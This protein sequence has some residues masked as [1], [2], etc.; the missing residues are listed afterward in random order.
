MP[1]PLEIRIG[2]RQIHVP[3]KSFQYF[4]YFYVNSG[5]DSNVQLDP[6]KGN[7]RI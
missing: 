5:S 2:R 1:G 6:W 7:R 4:R 3:A